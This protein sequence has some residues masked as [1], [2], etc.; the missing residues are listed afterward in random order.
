MRPPCLASNDTQDS[1]VTSSVVNRGSSG[2][3]MVAA[4]SAADRASAIASVG[5]AMTVSAAL[6]ACSARAWATRAVRAASIC[7]GRVSSCRACSASAIGAV[8]TRN[9]GDLRDPGGRATTV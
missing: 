4:S 2:T 8:I 5:F 7:R 9:T 3:V 6:A 1:G